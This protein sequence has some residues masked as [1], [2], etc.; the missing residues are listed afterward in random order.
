MKKFDSEL[1]ERLSR[2]GPVT[3]AYLDTIDFRQEVREEYEEIMEQRQ[4]A[5]LGREII[6]KINSK[7]APANSRPAQAL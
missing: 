5:E 6:R 3:R 4:G 7:S 2:P 1:L